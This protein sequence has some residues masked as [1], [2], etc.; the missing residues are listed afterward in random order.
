MADATF[1]DWPFFDD[2]HRRLAERLRGDAAAIARPHEGVHGDAAVAREIWQQLCAR[3]YTREI[4]RGEREGASARID[5]RALALM[6]E[7]LAYYT[8]IA[9]VALSEPWLAG[10]PIAIAGT[11]EQHERWLA[12]I[13]A[14]GCVPAFALSE[15]E[16][17]TDVAAIASRAERDGDGWRIR[18]TKTWT[19]NAGAADLYVVFAKLAGGEGSRAISAFLVTGDDPGVE[20]VRRIP[21]MP[22]HAVGKLRFD[23]RVPGNALL[24]A[25]GQGMALAL[26]ALEL[27]RPTVG[28]ATL[29]FA[30]RALDEALAR[31]MSRVAFGKRLAE[32]QLIQ[33]KLAEMAVG[34]DRAALLVYRACWMHD[35]GGVPIARE[36]AMAKLAATEIAQRVVDEAVQIFGASGV[37]KGAPVERMYREVRAFRIFD[38]ASDIQKLIIARHVLAS[39]PAHHA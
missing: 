5:L 39:E 8:G 29:G 36:A 3:G 26:R 11:P 12:P 25:P 33:K 10:L 21:V 30:R 27:F 24:G 9:D 17:G 31:A 1:L 23:C 34:I 19:S 32:Y 37:V 35:V 13:I 4:F 18:A 15:P 22:P 16:A 38:G 28:A 7:T 20:L 2:G 6:R 14:G